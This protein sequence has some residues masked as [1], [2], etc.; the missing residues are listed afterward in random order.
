[1]TKAEGITQRPL[2]AQDG[3]DAKVFAGILGV[4]EQKMQPPYGSTTTP[5]NKAANLLTSIE[6]DHNSPS[7]D[8]MVDAAEL[9]KYLGDVTNKHAQGYIDVFDRDG[10]H[11]LNQTELAVMFGAE[12]P[13]DT[14]EPKQAGGEDGGGGGGSEATGGG[15]GGGSEATGGASGTSG[16]LQVLMQILGIDAS[17]GLSDEEKKKLGD[18]VKKYAGEDGQLD[19]TELRNGLK[20]EAS[21]GNINLSPQQIDS[22]VKGLETQLKTADTDS[23][24]GIS[25]EE[26]ATMLGTEAGMDADV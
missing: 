1:M 12:E 24:A 9:S 11:K 21:V 3:D 26:L 14:G 20:I 19:A 10:D 6:G 5:Q 22:A 18:F 17:D 25:A 7:D 23:K 2:A 4:L 15:G 16:M 13:K 8:K